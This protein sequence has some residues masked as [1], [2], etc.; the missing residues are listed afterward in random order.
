MKR[1]PVVVVVF[2]AASILGCPQTPSSRA[3]SPAR[4][5]EAAALSAAA[6]VAPVLGEAVSGCAAGAAVTKV[7]VTLSKG[8]S[9]K[10]RADVSP[11][12]V[13]VAP[14]GIIRWKIE[15]ECDRLAGTKDDPAFKLTRPRL[16]YF[17]P[18]ENKVLAAP[19]GGGAELPSI[20]AACD[21][22]L[23]EL[24]T[25]RSFLYCTVRDDAH[26]GIYKYGVEGREVDPLDPDVEVRRGNGG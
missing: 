14:G 23:T 1:E 11:A 7:V 10:C 3:Q 5:P 2:L 12:L 4:S 21:T 20:L 9:R 18:A 15:N 6:S 13:C 24:S 25:G 19:P 22:H 16:R 17:R 8:E 26:E